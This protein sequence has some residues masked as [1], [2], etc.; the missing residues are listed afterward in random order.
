MEKRDITFIIL[1]GIILGF[2]LSFVPRYLIF[3]A[4]FLYDSTVVQFTL[5]VP[6]AL[7]FFVDWFFWFISITGL[8]LVI[9]VL[10]N[11]KNKYELSE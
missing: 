9:Y 5:S 2:L 3:V 10:W 11:L 8:G 7:G 4:P 1:T 6:N